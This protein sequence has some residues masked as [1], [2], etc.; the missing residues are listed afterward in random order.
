M[1]G[2]TTTMP[3]T[4]VA[5][6]AQRRL[7]VK[8]RSTLMMSISNEHQLKFNSIKDAKQLLQAIE[9]RFVTTANEVFT[10]STQ[11]NGVDNL[12]DA[13]ICAFL[14]SQPNSPQLAHE[15]L[16]QI[17]PDDIKEM[18]LRWPI[19][20][21]TAFKNSNVNQMVNTVKGNNVNTARPKAVVNAVKGNLVNAV[22]ALAC[23][24]QV[25]NGVGPQKKLIF[26]PNVQGN[27]QIDLQ[28]KEVIDSG[29]SRGNPKGGKLQE[30]VPLKLN[31]VP[32]GGL[33]RLFAKA[34][35]DESKLWHRRL[36]HLNFKTMNKLVKE[37]LVK[38]SGPDWLSDI[39]APT[40]TMN[41]EPI[42]AGT[43]S[44]DFA[45][46]KSS[47]DDGFKPSSN[48]GKKVDEDPSKENKCNDQ[49][50]KDNV[51]S[52]N[53]VNTISLTVNAAGTNEDNELSFDPNMPASEDVDTFDFSNKNEDN[54]IVADI[55]NKDT[56]IQTINK[57]IE[58][59]LLLEGTPKE[60]KLQ[61][62]VPLKLLIN[63]SQVL[64]RAPRKNN[65]Y[66]VDLKN[67]VSKGGL[68]CM[69]AKSTYDESKL[70]HRRL[71]HLNFKT[72][73]K[74]VKENLVRVTILD[75]KGH[76][77]KCD[78]KADERFFFG[79]SM[80]SKAFRVFNSG[81]R[82][83]EENLHI[84][85]SENTPNVV[86]TQFN[87]FARTKASDNVGQARKETKPVKDYILLPLWTVDLPFLQDPKSSHDDVLKPSSN[88]GKKVDE[89]P[90]KENKYNELSF[91]PNMPFLEDVGT[92]DF[93][94]KDED[95]DIVADINNKDTK[96]QVSP[97][98]TT[99]IH[100][101]CPLDQVIGDIHSSTETRQM[102]VNSAFLYEKIE[103]EVCVCQPP[104][105]KDPYFPDRVYKVEKALYG[106][107]QALRAWYK[108]LSTYLLD[109]GFQRGKNEKTLFIKRHKV[110]EYARYQ[111]NPKVSHL[112]AVKKIFRYLKGH[113]KLGLW[114]PKDSP[115][116]LVAYT[117]NDY[118][119]A[120]LD[121][122]STIRGC[123][124]LGFNPTIYDS[125]IE[126]FWSTAMA[127][128]INEESQI[129]ARK[130][131][132]EIITTESFVRRD[133]RLEDEEGVD[134]LP[135]FTIFENL[136]LMGKPKRK[137]TRAP[138]PSGSTKHFT[139][140][141]V[142]KELD[143]RLLRAATTASSLEAEQDSGNIDKTQ[144][145]TTPNEDS[146]LRTTL[147]G[148]PRCQKVMRDTIAQTRF[149]NVSKL[150][151]DLVL[152]RARVDS[153]KDDQS[154]GEDASKQ[155]RKIHDIDG[156]EDITL[157]NDQKVAEMFDVNDLQVED[158][159]TTKL[160]VD[161]AQVNAAGK[162]NGASITTTV[163]AA[164][165]ITTDEITLA[166]A[167]MEIK[168]SKPKVKRVV[169]QEP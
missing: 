105:F 123:H 10:A 53:V 41:Y 110:C 61:E 6:K 152:V 31:I 34:T 167:L 126:Q 1:E 122:K 93:S 111:V 129:D 116:D 164:A 87:D 60:G 150:S 109:N 119:R 155:R 29:C 135:N 133:L 131:G 11:V 58:D 112:H 97:I 121:R 94:N 20:N 154:L 9:K 51:S 115:F 113:P 130:D 143:D 159:N 103:E 46:P 36:G 71:G 16:K 37:N 52:S 91:D 165:T 2:V 69:F 144:S 161:A 146:S 142:Y 108:T 102:D 32:K 43:R 59:M 74:L 137:N 151:N 79:Y 64:L 86:G 157:V 26:L 78:G 47:H 124:I 90:S 117:D 68:T 3:I 27:P 45:D 125:C 40:R 76:L 136:E 35:S 141:V 30:N 38:G 158:I 107:H 54:D 49:E 132:K 84:R 98:Q 5:D 15:D 118:A 168:T 88:D 95:D 145:K 99:R 28:D 156:D 72:M 63:E 4:S 55:N 70:W 12:R 7:E 57:L 18:D 66:S 92:F 19:H 169:I 138:Q 77:G 17:H 13:I 120:S 101:D 23:W 67:I 140:E 100:K 153:S 33:T 160:I 166:Q 39:D 80:N 73:N 139:D 81:T 8:A 162:V 127:K 149:E 65:M 62:K 96:I 50:K 147:D 21:N 89:D 82:I 85:F 22:K 24:I 75:T 56:T 42:V 14:A 106:Q 148:G 25:N 128:T 134:C 104:G 114:Y 163:S 83:V 44:N 48:D